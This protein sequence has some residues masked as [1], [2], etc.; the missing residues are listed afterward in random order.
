MPSDFFYVVHK[1]A[2]AVCGHVTAVVNWRRFLAGSA[3]IATN[4]RGFMDGVAAGHYG[5]RNTMPVQTPPSARMARG[6]RGGHVQR[7]GGQ[8]PG[9]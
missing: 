7:R 4:G 9:R 2:T 8:L 6:L 1:A 3:Q 5:M